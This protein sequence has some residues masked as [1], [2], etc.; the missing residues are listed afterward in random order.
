MKKIWMPIAVCF[1]ALTFVACKKDAKT[2]VDN[3]EI[4]EA[5][6]AKIK[7]LGFSTSN[8]HKVAEGYLVEGDIVLTDELLN[9]DPDQ[10][11][12]RIA[13]NEQ[14]RTTN[15]VTHLPRTITVNISG[16]GQAY[17]DGTDL[18]IARYNA[19]NLQIHFQR[20]TSN[21]ADI[22]IVGFNQGPSGGYITLGSSGFPTRKGDPYSQIKMNTNQYA[23]GSNPDVNYVGSVIQH[24]IGHCIGFRHTD[25]MDRSYSCGGAYS[26]E[27]ASNIGAILIPGTPSGP[28][29]NSWMLACSNGGD[30]TF[31]NNDKVALNYLY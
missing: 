28:D 23:Y 12:L 1:T 19:L 10:S 7:T 24:E 22:S 16:L 14:Y 30:R 31:N 15:L 29:A 4:S 3:Q 25:Y 21:R 26:N 6:M 8:I 9:S 20:V 5:T 2:P 27:G 11:L 17:I 18:A 13:N